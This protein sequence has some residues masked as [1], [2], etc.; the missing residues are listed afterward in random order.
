MARVYVSLAIM[1]NKTDMA[2]ELQTRIKE[3]QRALGDATTDNDL[4]QR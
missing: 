4:N 1:K 2:H 3:S